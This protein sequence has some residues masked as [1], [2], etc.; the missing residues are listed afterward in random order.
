MLGQ[1]FHKIS[2]ENF[3]DICF[4]RTSEGFEKMAV[5]IRIIVQ[6]LY[7]A[8]N[9]ETVYLP[10]FERKDGAVQ[11]YSAFMLIIH[12]DGKLLGRLM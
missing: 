1:L 9:A 8:E 2:F 11:N 7:W 10:L 4:S 6:R 12:D 3:N 5:I